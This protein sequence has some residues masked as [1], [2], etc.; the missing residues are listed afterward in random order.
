[1]DS[2]PM[3]AKQFSLFSPVYVSGRSHIPD[4]SKQGDMTF[5]EKRKPIEQTW[6]YAERVEARINR[7]IQKWQLE[8]KVRA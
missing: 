2:E 4:P 5:L 3:T 6:N 8:R 1:V 7:A